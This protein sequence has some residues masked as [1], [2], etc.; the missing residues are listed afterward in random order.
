MIVR[1]VRRLAI[2]DVHIVTGH[3]RV[4]ALLVISQI[5]G[6]AALL[7]LAQLAIRMTTVVPYPPDHDR[8][9]ISE[10][11]LAD[12]RVSPQRFLTD[13]TSRLASRSDLVAFG[14]TDMAR[15]PHAV[16]FWLETDSG[17]RP[18]VARGGVVTPGWLQAAG[19][20]LLAG[21]ALDAGQMGDGQA[22]VSESF[23]RLLGL[24]VP[25]ALG[26]M[27]HVG[28][29]NPSSRRRV[30]IVGV[31]RSL[32]TTR[33]QSDSASILVALR[34]FV[35]PTLQV[36]VRASSYDQA[37]SA[38]QSA[39]TQAAPTVSTDRAQPL[40]DYLREQEIGVIRLGTLGAW[41]AAICLVL[42]TGG[43]YA[44]VA[45]A[46]S[47]RTREFGLR[48]ALGSTRGR[49]VRLVLS[50]GLRLSTV[51]AAVGLSIGAGVAL[52]MRAAIVGIAILDPLGSA[53]SIGVLVIS[54]IV[55][56]AFPAYWASRT[57]PMTALRE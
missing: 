3:R 8:I 51:G 20:T 44:I 12:T 39:V 43:T 27:V 34:S 17:D 29:P 40:T 41:L 23:C 42:A 45:A 46:T 9:A 50:Q 13:V 48:L 14:L 55:A 53:L 56:S 6:C 10:F 16:A 24:A 31:F 47:R 19:G 25:D 7:F 54:A 11:R 36:V 4:S 15:A 28:Y 33:F 38:L 2:S 21:H 49:I 37:R 30:Q 35:S 22:L 32:P 1:S 57:D 5:A 18:R 26:T 52:L